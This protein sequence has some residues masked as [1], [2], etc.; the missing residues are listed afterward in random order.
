MMKKPNT[1]LEMPAKAA[2]KDPMDILIKS[3]SFNP[4]QIL[5]N[6]VV[7]LISFSSR[8]LGGSLRF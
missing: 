6:I 5:K 1:G 3:F 7:S 8:S 2:A 4:N